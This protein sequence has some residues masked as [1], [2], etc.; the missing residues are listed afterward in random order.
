MTPVKTILWDT[1]INGKLDCAMFCHIDRAPDK[2]PSAQAI[3]AA[4]FRIE[5]KDQSHPPVTVKLHCLET[6]RLGQLNNF[7]TWA[8]HG[9]DTSDFITMQ[10]IKQRV[11]RD[12]VLAIY[13]YKKV[14]D[15]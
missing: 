14:P 1:N 12:T 5:T 2:M 7:Q 11:D 3:Q 9:M 6:F 15:C 13:F 8:S 10:H 4:T